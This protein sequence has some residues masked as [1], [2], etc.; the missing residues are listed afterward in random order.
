MLRPAIVL[1]QN[2]FLRL[3]RKLYGWRQRFSEGWTLS[4]SNRGQ[5]SREGSGY[6]QGHNVLGVDL[7]RGCTPR[8]KQWKTSRPEEHSQLGSSDWDHFCWRR[9]DLSSTSWLQGRTRIDWQLLEMCSVVLHLPLVSAS[10]EMTSKKNKRVRLGTGELTRTTTLTS[11]RWWSHWRKFQE[12]SLP[13]RRPGYEEY[14]REE[15]GDLSWRR[16]KGTNE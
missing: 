9:R 2:A 10:T 1:I 14:L 16:W 6:P 13:R 12:G 4:R 7:V 11:T 8:M 15:Q 5:D 3:D